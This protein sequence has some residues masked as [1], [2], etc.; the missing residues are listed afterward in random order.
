[1]NIL[2]KAAELFSP[3]D[4]EL[5]EKTLARIEEQDTW[6]DVF[7]TKLIEVLDNIDRLKAELR[8][9]MRDVQRSRD[10]VKQDLHGVDLLK[11]EVRQQML[12]VEQLSAQA[13]EDLQAA[14][15]ELGSSRKTLASSLS[16]LASSEQN[17]DAARNLETA[18]SQAHSA[19]AEVYRRTARWALVAT[20]LSA[21]LF[22]W[23]SWLQFRPHL[24]M[25]IPGA[26]TTI[27]IAAAVLIVN[28]VTREA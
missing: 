21:M 3:S 20:T 10:Q 28:R 14:Q 1:M 16:N 27:C 12:K 9:Q 6:N 13:R 22:V 5:I 7:S 17:L 18:A 8:Q 2:Q 24:P 25:W 19:A 26:T 4:P 11:V 15:D 23:T